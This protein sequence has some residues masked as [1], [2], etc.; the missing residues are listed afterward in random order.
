[1]SED[2]IH[3]PLL[4]VPVRNAGYGSALRLFRERDGSRCAVAFTSEDRLREV[5]GERQ[6]WVPLAE[7]A[8]RDLARPLG[9]D[10]LVVDPNLVAPPVAPPTAPPPHQW[11]PRRPPWRAPRSGRADA[12]GTPASTASSA[13]RSRSEPPTCCCNCS[14]D[15]RPV[16][17]RTGPAPRPPS[18]HR[19]TP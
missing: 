14:R 7:P 16:N 1:M 3:H 5:L 17:G 12:P 6:D 10:A 9:V 2:H 19:T 13:P 4:C 8:L 11:P 15:L 18:R